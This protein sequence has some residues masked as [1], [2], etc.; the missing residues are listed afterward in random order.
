MSLIFQKIYMH[1]I[2][3]IDAN[4]KIRQNLSLFTF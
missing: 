1:K 2:L 4:N 3:G